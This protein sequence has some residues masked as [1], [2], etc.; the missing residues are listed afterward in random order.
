M[1]AIRNVL[2]LIIILLLASGCAPAKKAENDSQPVG[3][4]S[5]VDTSDILSQKTPALTGE[6]PIKP[7]WASKN[8]GSAKE[9]LG[10]V[11]IV[12][13]FTDDPE[14]E[15]TPQAADEVLA[16]LRKT[17]DWLEAQAKKRGKALKITTGRDDAELIVKYTH[18]EVITDSNGLSYDDIMLIMKNLKMGAYYNKITQK[19]NT[20]NVAFILHLNKNGRS[21][22]SS[23]S[24]KTPS[25]LLLSDEA[26]EAEYAYFDVCM[27]YSMYYSEKTGY[28]L[29][30]HE[31]LHLFGAVDLYY[32]EFYEDERGEDAVNM[33]MEKHSLMNTYFQ[34]EIMHSSTPPN[35]IGDLTA[36]LIGWEET[37]PIKY[38]YFLYNN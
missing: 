32:Y 9:L 16:E 19:Y 8:A 24:V 26:Y 23:S 15:I 29:Y 25:E 21:Y 14:S 12:S 2:I 28:G 22:A 17:G 36:Y 4:E 27:I 10:D 3:S 31:L 34:K 30:A 38:A 37:V 11:L 18:P 7:Y 13:I 35:E 6:E 1:K 33:Y 20:Q 5:E